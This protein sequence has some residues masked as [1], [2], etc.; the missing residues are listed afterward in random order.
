VK[1][2]DLVDSG[3]KPIQARKL[4]A[5]GM[6]SNAA[7]Q[8]PKEF[9]LQRQPPPTTATNARGMLL[10]ARSNCANKIYCLC[11]LVFLYPRHLSSLFSVSSSPSFLFLLPLSSSLSLSSGTGG[12]S[13]PALLN[14]GDANKKGKSSSMF[15]R[16]S[17]FGS[18]KSNHAEAF[19]AENANQDAGPTTDDLF[20]EG[21]QR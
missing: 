21:T 19:A 15:K 17:L 10:F 16:F 6:R 3:L 18:G 1:Y 14:E 13:G 5:I 20:E 12:S 4:K 2:Q 11:S 9:K 8:T 7:A